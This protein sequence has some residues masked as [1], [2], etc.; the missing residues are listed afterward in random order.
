MENRL[1]LLALI[2]LEI[3]LGI[4]PQADRATWAM[5]NAPIFIILPLVIYFQPRLKL[6]AWTLRFMFLH[7][8]V[9]MLGGYYTYAKVPLGFWIQDL[10]G[11]ARNHYDRLGHFFQGFVPA[12]VFREILFK[13][14][15]LRKSKLLS[16]VTVSFCLAFSAIYELMEWLAAVIMGQGADA[17]LG[18]QGDMWDTQSD[19]LMALIGAI[20][21]MLIF[22]RWQDRN[23]EKTESSL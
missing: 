18:T 3:A 14:S 15:L 9:L 16:L 7:A 8:L 10:F 13:K 1:L 11:L 22:A 4:S 23:I 5:E 17:F 6:S 19:M 21:A 20:L 12:L 2:V